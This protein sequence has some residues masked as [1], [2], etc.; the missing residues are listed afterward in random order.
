MS[1]SAHPGSP[2][3]LSKN[4]T[5]SGKQGRS[6]SRPNRLEDKNETKHDNKK[7]NSKN[8]KGKEKGESRK[9]EKNSRKE[10]ELAVAKKRDNKNITNNEFSMDDVIENDSV[11]M[12]SRNTKTLIRCPHD[13]QCNLTYADGRFI[14]HYHRCRWRNSAEQRIVEKRKKTETRIA[15]PLSG[16]YFLC[17][18]KNCFKAYATLDPQPIHYHLNGSA[19]GEANA[20]LSDQNG[21]IITEDLGIEGDESFE[22]NSVYTGENIVTNINNI[23]TPGDYPSDDESTSSSD[24]ENTSSDT[25]ADSVINRDDINFDLNARLTENLDNASVAT[26]DVIA[27][28]DQLMREVEHVHIPLPN[29]DI[30]DVDVR[31]VERAGVN[32][33]DNNNIVEVLLPDRL[34]NPIPDNNNLNNTIDVRVVEQVRG[35]APDNGNI[36]NVADTRAYIEKAVVSKPFDILVRAKIWTSRSMFKDASEGLGAMFQDAIYKLLFKQED[37]LPDKYFQMTTKNATGVSDT[38]HSGIL[39]DL[40]GWSPVTTKNN[41]THNPVINQ[42]DGYYEVEIWQGLFNKLHKECAKYSLTDA[43]NVRMSSTF[44]RMKSEVTKIEPEWYW[45]PDRTPNTAYTILHVYQ[46]LQLVAGHMIAGGGVKTSDHF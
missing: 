39:T 13:C 33:L 22:S 31:V 14:P 4:S 15:I 7:K 42:Y 26:T 3:I 38:S 2:G 45:E 12:L 21:N 28:I 11:R 8:N 1:K 29:N 32:N 41:R 36:L 40:F 46:G 27:A 6:A 16:D 17:H 18:M 23:T 25:T 30:Q 10:R 35:Q 44:A 24:T 20:R 5:K 34:H 19:F 37:V 43:N 9:D